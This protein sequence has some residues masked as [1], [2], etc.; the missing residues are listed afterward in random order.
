[1]SANDVAV[2]GGLCALAFFDREDLK[3]RLLDN[4]EFKSYLELEPH[5]REAAQAFYS[6]RYSVTLEIL[7]RHKSDFFVDIFLSAHVDTL[8]KEIRQKALVQAFN[9]YSKLELTTLSILFSTP[10]TELAS[11]IVQL[12][13]HGKIKARLDSQKN[14]SSNRYH[15]SNSRFLLRDKWISGLEFIRHR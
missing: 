9:P 12:I 15:R 13:E 6:A 8:Y 10:I 1:L 14:V 4:S 3:T 2:Y 5:I 7:D 11:E